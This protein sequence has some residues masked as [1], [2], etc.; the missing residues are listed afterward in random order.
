MTKQWHFDRRLKPPFPVV[1][2]ALFA[3]W[4]SSTVLTE[5]LQIDSGSDKS[6]IP[7]SL[8]DSLVPR[9]RVVDYEEVFDFDGN[10][11]QDIPIYEVGIEIVGKTFKSIR[12]YGLNA[13]LGFIGRDL[14]NIFFVSLDGPRRISSIR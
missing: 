13:D 14:L 7:L 11:I 10:V 1:E 6:G 8:I 4:S 12:V 9:P 3:P 5:K 2:V